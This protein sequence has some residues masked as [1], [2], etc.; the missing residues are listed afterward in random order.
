MPWVQ[1]TARSNKVIIQN[2]SNLGGRTGFDCHVNRRGMKCID[3]TWL[4]GVVSG[5]TPNF[6][7]STAYVEFNTV[8]E[9]KSVQMDI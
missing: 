7:Q 1:Y 8:Q 2:I 4:G 3:L 5:G 9:S 6:N